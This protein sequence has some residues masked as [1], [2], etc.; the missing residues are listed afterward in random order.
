MRERLKL[1]WKDPAKR[2]ALA[3][4]FGAVGLALI[5]LVIAVAQI[6]PPAPPPTPTATSACRINCGPGQQT[7]PVTP[8]ILNLR[9]RS[10]FIEP[11]S[12][13]RGGSWVP[14][15]DPDKAQWVFGT[16]VNY[17]IGLS[18]TQAN[19]DMLQALSP[20]DEMT[21]DLS[22]GQTLK[23]NYAGRQFVS[24][25][26]V[27]IFSQQRPGLT[28]VLLGDN[29]NQRLVVTAD[30][31]ADSEVGQAVPS[32]L[33]QIGTPIDIG[34]VRVT[35]LGGRLVYNAPGVP[36]GSAFYLVDFTAEN[37]GSD[38]LDAGQFAMTLQDYANQKYPLSETASSLGPN[39][40]P[41]GQLLPGLTATFMAGFEVPTNVT[42]PV[43]VW[44][45]KPMATFRAQADV[46]VPL[47]GPTP[48]PDPRSQISVQVTQAY[49]NSDQT[50]MI[51]VAGVGN[52]TNAPVTITSSDI[53]LSTPDGVFAALLG[54]EP[55]L[56]TTL[57]PGQNQALTL[58]FSRL[59][60]NSSNLRI[61]LAEFQLNW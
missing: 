51:V 44:S 58:R 38:V 24:P 17:V 60:N 53:S 21:I 5:L 15:A 20:A 18:A 2:P 47:I 61:F 36:V 59:P 29:D 14:A 16:L 32:T 41:K 11:V 34:G 22:N 10:I 7:E 8:K 48:T 50:E 37:I 46:A 25:G 3:I 56:P 40:A 35:V 27:D 31:A 57:Q 43:L 26:S 19:N 55:G 1:A 54:A 30:Y 4:G 12:V 6:N 9:G 28:L 33:A 23:F 13:A 52:P 42:G 49:F 39:S 45:F